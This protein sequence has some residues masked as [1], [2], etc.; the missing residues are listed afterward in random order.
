VAASPRLTLA[1][2]RTQLNQP[3]TAMESPYLLRLVAEADSLGES[4]DGLIAKSRVALYLSRTGR[5]DDANHV[6]EF[7]RA[8]SGSVASPRVFSW[9]WVSEAV[10]EYF[11]TKSTKHREKLVR[12]LQISKA[13]KVEETE[14][15]AAAWLAHFA[16]VDCKY[17]EVAQFVRQVR[18]Q[19]SGA[20]DAVVRGLIVLADASLFSRK[21]ELSSLAYTKA[22]AA[23]R[24][25]GDRASL[26]A[27]IE[28]RA[29]LGL[30]RLWLQNFFG[31]A[32]ASGVDQLRSQLAGAVAFERVTR[33]EVLV[34]QAPIWESRALTLQGKFTEALRCIAD[35]FKIDSPD[36]GTIADTRRIFAAW[37]AMKCGDTVAMNKY[38]I[39][40]L[41]CD[42]GA[43]DSDDRAV[44]YRQLS[45]IEGCS[46]NTDRAEYLLRMSGESYQ[47]HVESTESLVA[48]SAADLVLA[49][50]H[51]SPPG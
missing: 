8:R 19:D 13:A 5:W 10:G 15:L 25:M 14:R 50:D 42:L 36:V 33:S 27:V 41:D 44:C 26:L 51:F 23:A 17:S 18:I 43:L 6:R 45:D 35:A 32:Q 3:V 16:F 31:T 38:S 39:S 24:Q 40:S 9:L 47:V 4:T 20:P 49:V 11:R 29:M 21:P 28:N 48:L 1:A 12:A 2:A 30:D 46:G 37:L 34:F 7:V 22:L